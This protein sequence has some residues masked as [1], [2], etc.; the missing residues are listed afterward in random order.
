MHPTFK[1]KIRSLIA[2]I[3]PGMLVAATGVGA[4]DLATASMTGSLLGLSILWA[5]VLGGFLK[6]VLTEGLARWQLATGE[7]FLEG[8][9]CHLGRPIGWLFLPYLLLWSFFVGSA[10][11]GACGVTLHAMMP[12]F[13]TAAAGKLFFGMVASLAGLAL[14]LAGGFTLF[15]RIMTACVGMMFACVIL[16][17]TL[18]WPGTAEIMTGLFIPCIPDIHGLGLTWTVALM[19]G[20][21]GTLTILCYGYWIREKGR[22]QAEDISTCR[23]DLAAGYVMTVLFGL[24]MVIIG[25]TISIKGQGAGLLISLADALEAP[26]GTAGRWLFLIGA[27]CAVFSSLL[28]V[29]QSVPYLFADVWTLFVMPGNR[30]MSQELTA[31]RPYRVYLLVLALV[32][33]LGLF[34]SFREVQ[35]IYAVIGAAFMPLLAAALLVLNGRAGWVGK[36]RNRPLTLLS[37]LATLA[38]FGA[39]AWAKWAA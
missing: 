26:L 31:S 12:V 5:V 37:L 34:F 14:V 17:A 27:F 8:V 13:E 6:F 1:P 16:T 25:S 24:A 20:V 11:M 4:G 9:A 28:G 33:M 19:G 29:W 3:L 32:P 30:Q 21:G 39:M 15:E 7:T 22:T 18:L 36:Y 2:V 35:K 10:L 38:F 23:I